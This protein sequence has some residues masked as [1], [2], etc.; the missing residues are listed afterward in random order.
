MTSSVHRQLKN[1]RALAEIVL[2]GDMSKHSCHTVKYSGV[3]GFHRV[4]A[5]VERLS[6]VFMF[7]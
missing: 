3:S 6:V 4:Y 7:Y 2:L 1:H 5:F